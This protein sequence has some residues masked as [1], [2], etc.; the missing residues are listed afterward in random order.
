MLRV[1]NFSCAAN[2]ANN[3]EVI[4]GKKDRSQV[5]GVICRDR[6]DGVFQVQAEAEAIIEHAIRQIQAD[7]KQLDRK[8]LVEESPDAAADL[9]SWA[10]ALCPS[11]PLS[12]V[13][14]ERRAG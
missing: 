1:A 6:S 13:F 8:A 14:C 4:M 5:A 10:D 7:Q 2:R 3:A 11:L 12:V 9:I